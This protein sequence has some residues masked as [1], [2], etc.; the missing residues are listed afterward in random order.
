M[1]QVKVFLDE[2]EIPSH[3]YNVVADMPHP[4]APL[5]GGDG[6]PVNPSSLA[7]I[8]PPA[9]IEQEISRERWVP[10]PEPVRE[11]YRQWRPTPMFRAHRLEQIVLSLTRR[12]ISPAGRSLSVYFVDLS[13]ET[14]AGSGE[15]PD[16]VT[17]NQD[18]QRWSTK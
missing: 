1:S 2:S 13:G 15:H 7:A 16:Y 8:F 4:P 6:K 18:I 11:I 3:W 10:I 12:E 9:I 5:L 17:L 14:T